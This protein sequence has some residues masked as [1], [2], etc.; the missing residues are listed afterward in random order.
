MKKLIALF[1]AVLLP[2]LAFARHYDDISDGL[3]GASVGVIVFFFLVYLAFIVLFIVFLIK[4]CMMCNDIRKMRKYMEW[5]IE[6]E[7]R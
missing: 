3:L 7:N 6:N 5:K 1:A 4:M 2:S